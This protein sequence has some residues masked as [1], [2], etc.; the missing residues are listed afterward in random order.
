MSKI[1]AFLRKS[2][3]YPALLLEG[4]FSER[5]RSIIINVTKNLL[6]ALPIIVIVS[7][8]FDNYGI[9]ATGSTADSLIRKLLGLGLFSLS[10]YI[11]MQIFEAYFASIY[12]FEYVANN[13]YQD[14]EYYT[15]SAGRLLRRTVNDN[16]LTGL[17]RSDGVGKKIITRLGITKEEADTLLLKQTENKNPKVLD[18][19]GVN[20]IKVSTIVN[21]IYENYS[22]F[23][24]LLDNHGLNQKDL[25][26]TVDWVIYQVESEAY[27]RQWWK[28]E[29][30]AHIPGVAA[31]WSFGRTYLLNKYS[32][33]ILDDEEVNSNAISF[34][35]RD[36]ELGQ[37]QAV[38]ERS[39][40]ANALLVGQPGEEKMEVVWNL[41]KQI[42][43][44]TASPHL[45][46]K[47]MLLFLTGDFT[48][49]VKDRN[50]FENKIETIFTEVL[51][52]GNIV[53][54]IDNF[55]HLILQAKQF[56][57]NLIEIIEPYLSN[58]SG[59]T[60]AL[61]DTE[62]FHSLI[63]NNKAIMS[64]F[65]SIQTKPLLQTEIIK[66]V[67]R[68]ALIAE[69]KYQIT[70]TYPAISEIAKSA[71]Y[72]FPDGVSSDKAEDL[73]AEMSPWSN[74]RGIEL[75]TRADVLKYI[76][77]KT[78][79]P[80][81]AINEIEKEKLLNL[82]NLLMKRVIAQREA[83]FA[84]ASAI[85]RNRAGIR[86]ELRPVGSFLFLGPTGVGKTETAKALASVFFGEEKALMRLDMSEY[87]NEEALARLIGSLEG[88]RQGVLSNLLREQ[89]YG[90]LLLD[91]FEK[92]HKDVLNLFLQIIDEGY[93]SD[94]WGKKV[95][96]R[97]I[98]FIATSNAGA[99]KIF[100]II[101]Q[102]KKLHDSESEI[103]A[104]VI[105]QGIFRPEL[106]NR[107][108]STVLFHPLTKDNLVDIAGLMLKK[109][110]KRLA[111][112]G[113]VF[114]SNQELINFLANGGYNPTFGARPMNRLIQDTIEE[115]L[116]D[117]I[118]RGDLKAGNKI[119]F[120]VLASLP[121]KESLKPIV[122]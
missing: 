81:A 11:T 111:N 34:E 54:V 6:L 13:R 94:V 7:I 113:I 47:K 15:F 24:Q 108:D 91:E 5:K 73:L 20:L 1:E 66:I 65:E 51:H 104:H 22:D 121:E 83:V 78:S 70:Y 64:R 48:S 45:V 8:I 79:I 84:V 89:P 102:G 116:S 37:L 21:F 28:A 62:Y 12:Y 58:I 43:S 56:E 99:D 97:N 118:I 49:A 63:E 32:R 50:D 77:E 40:G 18:L 103:I 9:S 14:K 95:M 23:K 16:L 68:E 25:Q 88:N 93:F 46:G 122:S 57:L 96:A 114:N 36:R 26:A 119:E 105:E 19:S 69:K 41:A 2:K 75:I 33:N 82:E 29:K 72:Y 3:I 101:N 80:I 112:K 31:D 30:L 27:N 17:L 55:A 61:V 85:R 98:I 60:I 35:G 10:L 106:I 100:N 52:A 71:E 39:V 92:T 44:G 109:V 90:V 86:D 74:E 76:S 120:N 117:L 38:L 107:F 53:L 59:Q 42:H 87:Q 110:A 115:H 67:S 4:K